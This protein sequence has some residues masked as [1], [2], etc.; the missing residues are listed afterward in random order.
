MIRAHDRLPFK[1]GGF[2]NCYLRLTITGLPIPEYVRDRG[3]D[4]LLSRLEWDVLPL[5]LIA[6]GVGRRRVHFHGLLKA[7]LT[8]TVLRTIYY[9]T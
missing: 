1:I 4:P 3:T 2:G 9:Y 8:A 5:T 7:S 6:L